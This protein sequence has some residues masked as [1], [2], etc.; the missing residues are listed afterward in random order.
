MSAYLIAQVSV[1]DPEEFRRYMRAVQALLGDYQCELLAAD[2]APELLEGEWP[3][4][5]T[6]IIRFADEAE[7]RRWYRSPEYQAAARFRWNSATS[8]MVLL[9]GLD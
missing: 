1:R 5:R 4:T 8:N 7:A 9:H 6:A 2:N 3:A